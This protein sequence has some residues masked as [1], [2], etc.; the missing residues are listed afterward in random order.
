MNFEVIEWQ[1]PW[2]SHLRESGLLIAK[3][4]NWIRAAND[5]AM[6][7]S[8]RNANAKALSFNPQD[9][10]SDLSGYETHIYRTGE[11]PTRDNFHDFFNALMWL[12]FPLIKQTLNQLHYREIERAQTLSGAENTRGR[13]RD[14]ATLFDENCA[15]VVSTDAS[16]HDRLKQRH[17]KQV[18]LYEREYFSQSCEVVIFGHALIEKLMTPYKAITAHVWDISVDSHWFTNSVDERMAFVDH[19]IAKEL[20]QGFVSADFSHLP[21]LGVPGWW[22]DQTEDFYDDTHVFRPA[23][24]V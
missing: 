4:A 16:I 6:Q 12:R 2:L 11:I 1:R 3:S 15:I 13:Q 20:S 14:A 7:Q 17:W 18:L 21:V 8:L 19:H 22:H 10:I 5:L 24:L 23:R 9:G